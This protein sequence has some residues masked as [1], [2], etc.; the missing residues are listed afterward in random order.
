MDTSPSTPRTAAAR[1]LADGRRMPAMVLWLLAGLMALLAHA[2]VQAQA[3]AATPRGVDAALARQVRELAQAASRAAVPGMRVEIELGELDPRLKLAPC[4]QVEPYLPSGTRLWGKARIGL[5]CLQGATRWNVFLPVTVQV[6]APS[7]VATRALATGA[8]LQADDFVMAETDIA[9]DPSPAIRL[10]AL[11][12]GRTLAR[13]L[14][15]G[16]PLHQRDLR[17]RQ[18]FAAG[19]TVRVVAQGQG[20][21]V[22]GEALAMSPGIEGQAVRIRTESGRI[23]SGVAVAERQVEIAL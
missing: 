3:E 20:Y 5:R 15:A 23:L 1:P 12:A 9:A 4:Q 18:W 2:G 10:P 11:V 22:A 7:L 13:P 14:A 17:A 21:S 19:E 8:S 6:F 16:E